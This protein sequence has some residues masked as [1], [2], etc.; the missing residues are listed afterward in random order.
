MSPGRRSMSLM[1]G[2]EACAEGALVAGLNYYAGYPITPSTEI[3][4]LLASRLPLQGGKFIQ[5]EDEIG[6]LAAVLGASLAG[7]KAM[8]ATSGPG[9]SLMQ[10]NIGFGIM[11]EIPAVI[12]NVQRLGPSTG[13]PTLTSQGDVMQSRW[14]CHG[15][16][17]IIALSPSTVEECF[18]LT[19]QAFNYAERFRTPVILLLEEIIG[20]LRETVS[21]P[22]RSAITVIRREKP[23]VAPG[24]YLPYLAGKQDPAVLAPFGEGY[25]FHVTGLFH[26]E[27]GFPVAGNHALMESLQLRLRDK[28]LAHQ[29]EITLFNTWYTDDAETLI[30]AYGS[31]ER[32]ALHALKQAR[33]EG[34][35]VGLLSLKTVWPFPC[36]LIRKMTLEKKRILIPEHN[37]GQLAR[38]IS[39]CVDFPSKIISIN[40]IDGTLIKPD[41]IKAH[42]GT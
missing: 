12:V 33:S 27:G 38:E 25:R 24:K 14:G 6:S 17:E 5:M 31:T 23:S 1:Q 7:S 34:I 15:D 2:N 32:S 11:A 19:M 26:D 29:E 42:I 9:F 37:M 41:K 8:T 21:L 35:R 20:H 28:I 30:I 18:T 36:G 40:Q 39:R 13:S 10:E 4:E 22:D 3:G 16:H